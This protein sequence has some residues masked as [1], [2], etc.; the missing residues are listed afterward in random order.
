MITTPWPDTRTD[1]WQ[2]DRCRAVTLTR[3]SGPRGGLAPVVWLHGARLAPWDAAKELRA[4]ADRTADHL[5]GAAAGL[6]A[7]GYAIVAPWTGNN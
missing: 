6:L 2:A 7:A 3:A 5:H 4:V 1:W